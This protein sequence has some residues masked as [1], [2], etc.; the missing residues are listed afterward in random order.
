M[1]WFARVRESLIVLVSRTRELLSSKRVANELDEEFQFHL[2][3][4]IA[5]N[6]KSGLSEHDARRAAM[7]AFGGVQRYRQETREARG[8]VSLDALLRDIRLSARR[9]RTAPTYTIGVI[10]TLALGLGIAAGI[11]ALVYGVMLRPLPYENPDQLIRISIYTPGLG[12]STTE[13][14][15]GTFVYF[16][17]RA[18][19]F[20]LLGTTMENEGVAITDGDV[21]ERVTA[22]MVSPSIFTILDT[23]PAAG[24]MLRDDDTRA[25]FDSPIMI[26]YDLWQRRFGGDANIAGKQVELNRNRRT[27]IGVLPAGF[28]YPSREA[29]IYYA[30]KVEAT[31]A[32][33]P[34]RYLTVI[35]RLAPNVSIE[36]AQAELNVLVS[37]IGERYA[38]LTPAVV[39]TAGFAARVQTVRDAIVEPVRPELTLLGIMVGA[40]LLIACANVATLSLLRAQRLRAE[41]AITRALGASEGSIVRRFVVE[42]V[43]VSLI[44]CVI[45]VPIAMIAIG[46]RFGLQN[47]KIP[48]LYEVAIT[49]SIV[50]TLLAISVVIGAILGFISAARAGG[51]AI[52]GVSQS[53]RVDPRTARSR[54]WRRAQEGLVSVQIS[55]ALALLLAAGLM[56]SSLVKLRAVNIGFE[57]ANASRFIVHLP[58]QPYPTFQKTA[59]FDVSLMNTLRAVPGVTAVAA[60]MQFPSTEQMLYARLRL[61]TTS[62][63][64]QTIQALATANVVTAD[65]FK[66]MGTRVVAGR[67]FERGDL[68]TATPAVVLGKSLA[69]ELFGADNPLGKELR[70]TS[71]RKYPHYRVV[72]ISEDVYGDR[73]TD[74]PLHVLYFPLLGELPAASTETEQR[75]PFMPGGMNYV[76]RSTR[77]L[78][79]LAP[80]FR[81]A[82]SSLDPRVPVWGVRTLDSIVADSTSRTRLTMLLLGLAALATL[83]LGAIGL[84]SVIAYAVAGRAREFAVRLAIGATPGAITSL[85]LRE[86]FRVAAI[87]IAGGIVLALASTTVLRDLLYQISATEPMMYAA[88]AVVVLTCTVAAAYSPAR[89]AGNT[90]PAR[91][92]QGE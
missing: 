35:G 57:S 63:S 61:E 45:A 47:F 39:R 40:L 27:I 10:T 73:L 2:D 30:D 16:A 91:V 53:L 26:S 55:L 22:A 58:F 71:S 19:S 12:I 37:R 79:E 68:N 49:P 38:E 81:R 92:L 23:K 43:L 29:A 87:G 84:Y 20:S 90:S 1:T 36:Q 85:V 46:S 41:I 82:V 28:G 69:R 74:G 62:A 32:D 18:K 48:R 24:R 77:P 25:G 59:A 34:N 80:E 72:G 42:G 83:L 11:G 9:L 44:G 89:R 7:N 78:S 52:G 8:F 17:E 5:H 54:G 75:I 70:L 4:E 3:Q 6:I 86:G 21:P 76:V 31:R 51:L 65:Y 14:S 67:E 15:A 66:V 88:A 56:G 60:A 13:N 64:G 33:L 50:I